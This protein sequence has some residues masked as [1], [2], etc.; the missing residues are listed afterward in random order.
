MQIIRALTALLLPAALTAQSPARAEPEIVTSGSAEVRLPADKAM[1]RFIVQT[2]AASAA[3]AASRNG[4][5][6]RKVEAAVRAMGLRAEDVKAT[7]FSVNPNYDMRS[8]RR[9]VDYQARTQIEV[10]Y[11]DFNQIGRLFDAGLGAGAT[12][13]TDPQFL[14]DTADRARDGAMKLAFDRAKRE[15]TALATAAGGRLGAV[16]AMSTSSSPGPMMDLARVSLTS[17]QMDLGAPDV[18][19]EVVVRAWVQV[20]WLLEP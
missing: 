10:T 19:R 12:E 9:V 2:G 17:G 16:R 8:G 13:V 15:A 7:G 20:R 3:E 18:I 5:V 1:V 4:E 11:R 14:S 6:V